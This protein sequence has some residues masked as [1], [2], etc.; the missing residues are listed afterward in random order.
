MWGP[1]L[2]ASARL[3]AVQSCL[4]HSSAASA[5]EAGCPPRASTL[6]SWRST[7]TG[8]LRIRILVRCLFRVG[9]IA[10]HDIADDLRDPICDV[11]VVAWTIRASSDRPF[12]CGVDV[13]VGNVVE[14]VWGRE[15]IG[16]GL[17]GAMAMFI[18]V[19]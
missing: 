9:R 10:P 16:C 15:R 5:D 3:F 14:V 2:D 12:S 4:R 13:G 1:C 17:R 7:S 18:Y 11:N 6:T 8:P 19:I